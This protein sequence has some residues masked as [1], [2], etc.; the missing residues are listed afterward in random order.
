MD[1]FITFL[2]TINVPWEISQP[3]ATS[4]LF[5][6][7]CAIVCCHTVNA[8]Q[9]VSDKGPFKPPRKACYANTLLMF[10]PR[11]IFFC[12]CLMKYDSYWIVRGSLAVG[13]LLLVDVN[14]AA[15]NKDLKIFTA[16]W[17]IWLLNLVTTTIPKV[18]VERQH[19]TPRTCEFCFVL[20][21]KQDWQ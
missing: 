12:T 19:L 16:I 4:H 13:I 7:D 20:F 1:I 17:L 8:S 5:N 21:L 11:F 14:G 15:T 2:Q 3:S 9:T 18:V 6:N 10:S